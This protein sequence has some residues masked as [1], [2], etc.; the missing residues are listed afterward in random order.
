MIRPLFSAAAL[1]LL[2]ACGEGQSQASTD[3]YSGLSPEI[4][5]WRTD[6]EATHPACST[7]LDGK[8]CQSFEVT[9]KGSKTLTPADR[10]SGATAKVVAAMIFQGLGGPGGGQP[11]SAFAEFSKTGGEWTR[12]ATAPVNLAT[13]APA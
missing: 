5:A 9:C 8:G 10:A 4:L 13:C 6:L 11:G 2:A 12:I 3:P 1:L 7:K